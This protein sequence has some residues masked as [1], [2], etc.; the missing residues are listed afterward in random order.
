MKPPRIVL[1]QRARRDIQ[2]AVRHYIAE[3]APAAAEGFVDSLERALAHI[4]K[5]PDSG[6]PRCAHLLEIP[7][8]RV[9]PVAKY[10]FLVF[11]LP[12]KDRIDIWR[13]LHAQRDI[14]AWMRN[15]ET[16]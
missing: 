5:H 4:T 6:S 12:H 3:Q 15:T 14:P 11:Y 1:R 16:T 2:D 9:W 7:E 13:V 10:P 8:L